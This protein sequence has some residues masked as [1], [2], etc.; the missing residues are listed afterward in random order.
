VKVA[1]EAEKAALVEVVAAAFAEGA[2]APAEGAAAPAEEAKAK[3]GPELDQDDRNKE[4]VSMM[5][6]E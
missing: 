5:R 1:A 2:A 6:N 3:D 4:Q